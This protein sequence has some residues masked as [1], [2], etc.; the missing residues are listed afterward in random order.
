MARPR[1]SDFEEKRAS[2]LASAASV[3]ATQGMDRASMAQIA[4]EAGVSKALLYHYYPGK[5][6]L[7]FAIIE[8]HLSALDTAIAAADDPE[9]PPEQRL[10]SLVRTVLDRYR[11][12]DD[13]HK[14]QLNAG[15]ALTEAQQETLRQIERRIVRRFAEVIRALRPDLPAH[16]VMPATMSLFGM[17][18]WVYLW[19]RD[20]GA[21]SRDDYARL[22]TRI[23]LGGLPAAA[24]R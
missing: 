8:G 24:A 15:P 1:A 14:V 17:M 18:N 11:G 10:E 9:I 22:A 6:A 21:I 23:M 7:I 3:F 2:L 12:A 4:A 16:L 13:A 5:G 19:F 20:G